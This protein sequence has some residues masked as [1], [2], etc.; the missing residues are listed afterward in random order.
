[1]SQSYSI[2]LHRKAQSKGIPKHKVIGLFDSSR[3]PNLIVIAP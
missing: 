3:D 1:M 2:K